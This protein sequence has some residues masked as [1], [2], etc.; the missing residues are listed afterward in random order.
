MYVCYV[1]VSVVYM[2][3]CMLYVCE[4]VCAVCMSV[5]VFVCVYINGVS[6]CM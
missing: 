4:C 1:S 2:S 6:V 3:E 5:S